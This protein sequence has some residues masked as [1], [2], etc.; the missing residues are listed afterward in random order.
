MKKFN[1]RKVTNKMGSI[2]VIE[3]V[4]YIFDKNKQDKDF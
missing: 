4:I 1:K 2:K 3:K